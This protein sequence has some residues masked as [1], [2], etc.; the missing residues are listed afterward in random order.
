MW[1]KATFIPQDFFNE[2]TGNK[3]LIYSCKNGLR[4]EHNFQCFFV[5]SNN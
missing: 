2:D 4:N 5:Y 1:G 3:I